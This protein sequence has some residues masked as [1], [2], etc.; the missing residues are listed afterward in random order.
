MLTLTLA[1][2]LSAPVAVAQSFQ[3]TG[4]TSTQVANSSPDYYTV[5]PGDTLWDI[6]RT[7]LGNPEYWPRLW[8]INDYITNPHWIYPGNRIAF[9]LGT[10]LE[11]PQVGL[12]TTT[13][14]VESNSISFEYA[15][16][17]CGP[18]VRFTA[19]IPSTR[20][21]ARGFLADSDDVEAYGKVYKAKSGHLW[22]SEGNLIY[23]KMDDPEAYDCGDTVSIFRQTAKKV[24]DPRNRRT[25]YGSAYDVVAEARI[26]H[27]VD[28]MVAAVVRTSYREIVRGD[29]VGPLMPVH[30]EVETREPSGTVAGHIIG[31]PTNENVMASAGETVFLSVGRSDGVRVGDSFYVVLQL[32]E[33]LDGE[34]EDTSLPESVSGRVVVVRVDEYTAV[35]KITDASRVISDGNRIVQ[36]LDQ[37]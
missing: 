24:R 15:E 29:L 26:V 18:D 8:S 37:R 36:K 30:V 14:K 27:R 4:T 20:Y 22:L 7:F 34:K 23:L 31:R 9:R 25:R 11:P 5:Q 10:N 2:L 17:Q 35:G 21:E 32:D 33:G 3:G 1:A 19:T 16:N 13:P 6:S 28:D 12:E